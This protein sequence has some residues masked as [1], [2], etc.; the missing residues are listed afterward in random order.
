MKRIL[1]LLL[2]LM[3]LAGAG[4]LAEDAEF[5]YDGHWVQFDDYFEIYMPSD[6]VSLELDDEMREQGILHLG[7]SAGEECWMRMSWN[8]EENAV[9][10]EEYQYVMEN[11][12][13][14]PTLLLDQNG[15]PL[16]CVADVANDMMNFVVMR[17]DKPGYYL[18]QFT[19]RNDAETL[20][21]SNMMGSLRGIQ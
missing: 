14:L 21:S 11:V 20:Y 17:D 19:P 7:C 2:S 3:L 10:I 12:I 4:A 5:E 15:I 16:L 9:T 8:A 1:A 18:F 13:G 6:W